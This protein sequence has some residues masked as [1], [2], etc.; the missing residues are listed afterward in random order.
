MSWR[1]VI[2]ANTAKLD[3][4]MGF[5]VVRGSE[6]TRVHLSEIGM[7]IIETTSVS[8]TAALLCEL[9]KMKV[10]VVFC[11]EKRNPSSELMPYYG[12]HDTSA[13]LR[14]QLKWDNDIKNAV[15]TEIVTDKV[16]K[17]ADHL[18]YR[19]KDEANL[20]YDYLSDITIGDE[21]NREGHAARV[22]FNALFG[23]EFTRSTENSINAALNYGYSL[24][25]SSFTREIVANGYITQ[26]GL[27]HDNMFNPFNLASDLMEPYRPIVDHRVKQIKP[28]RFEIEEKRE[29]LLVLQDE[30]IIAGRK[31]SVPN[32]IKIY[33][34]SVFD[35]LNER[36]VSL[37]KLYEYEYH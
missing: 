29:M 28:E 9:T 4:Q 27:F 10:K 16:R 12:S 35:A 6:T 24:I 36:D 33:C 25:L 3:Y 8:L 13:K 1:T 22:Y 2:V 11:D 26:L 21:T 30:V 5:M 7:L 37:I 23:N 19:E 14:A 15:W 17:Q 31:E 34:K 32:A 20:L 18:T